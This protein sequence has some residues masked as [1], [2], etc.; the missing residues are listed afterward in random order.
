MVAWAF[1]GRFAGTAEAITA[2]LPLRREI[3]SHCLMRVLYEHVVTF[4]WIAAGPI[5][6]RI[7]LFK[8]NDGVE[9]IKVDNEFR[10]INGEALR[11]EVRAYFEGV[12]ASISA[13]FPPLTERALKA[14]EYWA[15]RIEGMGKRRSPYSFSGFYRVLYRHGSALVHPTVYG[16]QR[17]VT[18]LPSGA[19]QVHIER[20]AEE[21]SPSG[22]AAI[23]VG[24]ALFVSADVLGWPTAD[25]IMAIFGQFDWTS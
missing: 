24:Q 7:D 18:D 10:Q 22:M 3:D 20:D 19:K 17:L 25:E 21:R 16:L 2:L 4:A 13:D 6:E 5:K 15:G 12:C 23:L 9:R 11:P 14:D 1:L 8:K